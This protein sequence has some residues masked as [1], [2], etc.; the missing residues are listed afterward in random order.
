MS[1]RRN[2]RFLVKSFE[3]S[4][5]VRSSY[6]VAK[7]EAEQLERLGLTYCAS[8][9]RYRGPLPTGASNDRMFLKVTKGSLA[10]CELLWDQPSLSWVERVEVMA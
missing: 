6:R 7:R 1:G 4:A 5:V 2:P 10:G 3:G 9:T 8:V